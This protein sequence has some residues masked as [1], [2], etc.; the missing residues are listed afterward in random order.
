MRL[1]RCLI[2]LHYGTVLRRLSFLLLAISN[3]DSVLAQELGENMGKL[4]ERTVTKF[5]NIARK[6]G[7]I[8]FNSASVLHIPIEHADDVNNLFVIPRV[9]NVSLAILSPEN[10]NKKKA[11]PNFSQRPRAET[12]ATQATKYRDLSLSL[13]DQLFAWQIIDD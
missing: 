10:G 11:R 9:V 1:G 5:Y 2:E 7:L 6:M 12:L 3:T 8:K 4:P 13:A